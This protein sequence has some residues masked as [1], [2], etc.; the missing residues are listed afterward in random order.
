M[1]HEHN[2]PDAFDYV[3]F[4]PENLASWDAKKLEI[5]GLDTADFK[6]SE[7]AEARMMKL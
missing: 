6:P 7:D 3:S 5:S 4:A 1:L 2:R